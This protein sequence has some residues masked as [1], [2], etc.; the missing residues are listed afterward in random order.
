MR[1][2]IHFEIVSRYDKK[3]EPATVAVPLPK[4]ELYSGKIKSLK[5]KKL[6]EGR[7]YPAQFRATGFWEDGTVRWLLVHFLGDLPAN[8]ETDYEL[9]LAA[10]MQDKEETGFPMIHVQRGGEYTAIENGSMHIELAKSGQRCIDP[11]SMAVYSPPR[12]T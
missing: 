7:C 5:L 10:E 2:K 8:Q 1:K 3:M 12:C 4:G 11:F 6:P 9:C